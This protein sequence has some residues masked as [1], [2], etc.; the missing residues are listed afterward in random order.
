MTDFV[1][2]S[3]QTMGDYGNFVSKNRTNIMTWGGI[4]LGIVV[5][6]YFIN[7]YVWNAKPKC[8]NYDTQK[9]IA[10]SIDKKLKELDTC[11][12]G[13]DIKKSKIEEFGNTNF[14]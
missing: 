7:K 13:A 4:I 9:K 2:S 14:Y 5:I 8:V 1:S 6:C 12:C 10:D 3:K 11:D